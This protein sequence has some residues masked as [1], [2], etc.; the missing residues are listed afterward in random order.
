MCD[1][2]G[3]DEKPMYYD[4]VENKL[5]ESCKILDIQECVGMEEDYE[6]IEDCEN[7]Q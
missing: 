3:C 2:Q 6:L 7:E 1:I 5:C 4:T